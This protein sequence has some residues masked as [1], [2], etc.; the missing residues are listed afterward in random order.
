LVD[1]LPVAAKLDSFTVGD[2]ACRA[3]ILKGCVMEVYDVLLDAEFL[4]DGCPRGLC[5]RR[6]IAVGLDLVALDEPREVFL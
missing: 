6:N 1:G 3:G 5:Y 2:A 4:V